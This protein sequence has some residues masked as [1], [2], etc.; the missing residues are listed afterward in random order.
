MGKYLLDFSTLILVVHFAAVFLL[1]TVILLQ[2][3]KG[4]GIG[5][6]FGAGGSQSLFGA[7]GASTLLT[8]ITTVSAIVFLLTSLCL[9]SIAKYNAAG[10]KNDLELQQELLKQTSPTPE[11]GK[12]VPESNVVVPAKDS[13]D[14]ANEKTP[15]QPTN[16]V[17]PQ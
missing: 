10:G 3:G 6:A 4:G 2:S 17:N 12:E 5:A 11:S 15:Q 1:I 13:V 7:R 16:P 14:G 9:A 8:K